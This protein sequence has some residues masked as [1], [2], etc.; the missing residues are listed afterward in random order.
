MGD[1]LIA[2]GVELGRAAVSL[3]DVSNPDAPKLAAKVFLGDGWSWS[4]ANADEKAFRV[5]PEQGLVLLPWHGRQGTNGWFQG[6]QLLDFTK[7]SLKLRGTINHNSA[8]RRAVLLDSHVLSLSGGELV[9]AAIA[10]R[11]QPEVRSV[12][13]LSESVD[14]L[15][16]QGDRLIQISNGSWDASLQAQT[17]PRLRLSLAS[18]PDT[19]LSSLTSICCI[20]G[21]TLTV[22]TRPVPPMKFGR[23]FRGKRCFRLLRSRMTDW[24]L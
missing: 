1:R 8:A 5:F 14:Q 3:F 18:D 19:A 21:R 17:A 6:V 22:S 20:V 2:M 23:R 4:E 12:L 24:T 16:V 7:D 15:F 9:S 11:D 13:A 10:D